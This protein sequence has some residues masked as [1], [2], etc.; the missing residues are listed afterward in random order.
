VEPLEALDRLGLASPQ[1]L[2]FKAQWL[3][4]AMLPVRLALEALGPLGLAFS[5]MALW[6]RLL[7][8]SP[9]LLTPLALVLQPLLHPAPK[10]LQP[11]ARLGQRVASAV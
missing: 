9:I 1:H 4:A 3:L 10:R 7:Q 2:P 6:L 5:P 8:L 11:L